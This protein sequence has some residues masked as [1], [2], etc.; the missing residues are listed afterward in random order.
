MMMIVII[1]K[2]FISTI[3]SSNQNRANLTQVPYAHFDH[4]CTQFARDLANRT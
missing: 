4:S 1:L 3:M 2:K